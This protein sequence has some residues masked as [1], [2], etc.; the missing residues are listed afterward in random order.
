MFDER[1]T[2]LEQVFGTDVREPYSV[3][4]REVQ[5]PTPTGLLTCTDAY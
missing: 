5:H 2:R 3:A 4:M 1:K